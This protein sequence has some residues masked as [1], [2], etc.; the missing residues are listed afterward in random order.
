MKDPNR[1][2]KV[3]KAMR[4]YLNQQGYSQSIL[5][6]DFGRAPKLARSLWGTQ[7]SKDPHRAPKWKTPTGRPK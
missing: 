7:I 6:K 2:P 3:A 4:W 5:I 1:A